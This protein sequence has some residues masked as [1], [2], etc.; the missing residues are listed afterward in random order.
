MKPDGQTQ[1]LPP[2]VA[3][4][5]GWSVVFTLLVIV[6]FTFP[7][8]PSYELDPSWR[9]ALG[10]FFEEGM[11]FGSDVVFTYGPLGFIMGKTFSGL[12]FWSLIAGQ[13]TLAV[14]SA[15]VILRQGLRIFGITYE[16]ALHMVVI[17]IL[18]FELLRLKDSPRYPYIV[19]IGAVLALYSQI[20]FTDLLLASYIILLV[21]AYGLWGKK[22]RA[23]AFLCGSY[24]IAYLGIWIGSGQN[25]L[26]LPAYLRGS[27]E[28]SQGYQWAMGSP[29]PEIP[30]LMGL[31]VLGILIVYAIAHVLLHS[32]KPRAVANTLLLGAF[33]YLNWKHG[34]VRAD[35]HM[36][37]FFY[38]A[39]LPL[40]TYPY[41]L[42]DSLRFEDIH[43]GNRVQFDRS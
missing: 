14:I 15:V 3:R 23:V 20:K 39:L 21:T 18:G 11:Q 35:G 10:Y 30:L 32:N 8:M 24:L 26:N 37:G 2:Q 34:F 1:L 42:D 9:M 41:L 5:L 7:L 43:R 4:L 22:W 28:I 16:D 6:C 38:C 27:W 36:I 29:S 12:Q 31:T 25:V 33:I 13:L 17:G 19:L 40:T